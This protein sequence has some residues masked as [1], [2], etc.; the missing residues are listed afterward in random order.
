MI[1]QVIFDMDGLMFDTE[2]LYVRALEE[3]VAPKTGIAFPR[4]SI[5]KTLGTNHADFERMFPILF[6]TAISFDACYTMISEWMNDEMEAH[7]VP[8][9]PGLYALLDALKRACNRDK[10]PDRPGVS[11]ANE[12]PA[13]LRRIR[14]RRSGRTRKTGPGDLSDCKQSFGRQ[15][16][17]NRRL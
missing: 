5:L 8:V 11:E 3:Y 14:V 1:R 16:G 12:Y 7:G 10:P 2:R 4:E 6:G 17:R 9:K 13:I 15:A